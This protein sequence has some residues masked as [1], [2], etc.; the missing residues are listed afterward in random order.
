MSN[1][2]AASTNPAPAKH[3]SFPSRFSEGDPT[4]WFKWYEISCNANDWNDEMKAKKLPT[5][6]GGEALVTWL[7]LISEQQAN[8]EQA[9][10]NILER[11]GPVRFVTMDEFHRRRIFPGESL[12]VFWHELKRMIDRA[13]PAANAPTRQQLV[14]HQF[15]TGFPL[16]VSKRLRA[17]GA[18]EIYDLMQRAK[19]LMTIYW[20]RESLWK[21]AAVQ[22]PIDHVE[23]L[24][25]HVT[26]L[27]EQMAT[28][29]T[30]YQRNSRQPA[31]LLC[32]HCN[33]PGVMSL[34]RNYVTNKKMATLRG[35][36]SWFLYGRP[37]DK[38]FEL[39]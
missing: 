16:E 9:K 29:A 2:S 34:I 6:L 1:P 15:L 7:E 32:F 31:R 25:E 13:M 10:T 33:Q 3:I 20:C 19:L 35:G 12:S 23:A 21:I 39:S 17:A 37:L 24:T 30:N 28:M 11:M 26:A 36:L 27:T 38:F 18:G 5:L 14:I 8:Y 4:E 22:Q